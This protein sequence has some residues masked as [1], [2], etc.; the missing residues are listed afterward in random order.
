M[1][2]MV[3][4]S[5]AGK[6]SDLCCSISCLRVSN[7]SGIVW[8]DSG[9]PTETPAHRGGRTPARLPLAWLPSEA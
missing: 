9:D 3:S 4:R 2:M 5:T 8:R 7:L 1:R 6:V